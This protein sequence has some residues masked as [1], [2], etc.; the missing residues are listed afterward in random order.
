[1]YTCIASKGNGA[2]MLKVGTNRKRTKTQI[3]Q[4]KEE[5]ELKE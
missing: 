2:N 3:E 5:A 4:E 1:V